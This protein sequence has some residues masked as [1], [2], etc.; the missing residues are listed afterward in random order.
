MMAFGEPGRESVHNSLET[1]FYYQN[2]TTGLFPF[3]GPATGSF[4]NGAKS[5]TYH[6]WSLIA[7][8][9]YAVWSGDEAWVEEHWA[10]ITRGI[11]YIL[12]NI[13]EGS[14]LQNQVNT[15]DWARGN[16][17]GFNSALNALSY[18]ALRVVASLSPDEEQCASWL[19]AAKELQEQYNAL[20]WDEEA[21]LY[22]D[23][24]DTDV[25]PQDGNSLALLYGLPKTAEQR[26]AISAGLEGNWNDIGPVTPELADT[27]SPFIS[28]LELQAHL[29]GAEEPDRAMRLLRRLW[30]YLL[31]DGDGNELMTGSTF[32][33]GLASNGSL[34]YRSE[35]GYKY[36][37]AYTSMAHGW[38]AGPTTA[39]VTGVLGLR[40][41]G[42]GGSE[43]EL[44]PQMTGDLSSIRAGFE[45]GLG[46]FEAA[47][48]RVGDGAWEIELDVPRGTRGRVIFG[49]KQSSIVLN[50]VVHEGQSE[51]IVGAH[52][53]R[54]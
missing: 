26:A 38:S 16:T 36:D 42:L 28:G 48:D 51:I 31:G 47:V 7:M 17:G 43:W 4:R 22:L 35:A 2:A 37:A 46:W 23:N 50:G 18:H 24:T 25:H 11:N 13:D 39:L 52:C 53:R 32:A 30:G 29:H 45:A 9:D 3:A 44:R 33:E 15:N 12:D 6:S 40:L 34:Y 27:I 14:G 21:G 54:R 20:L 5:D 8:H 49:D 1:L 10:N 19:R 41:T